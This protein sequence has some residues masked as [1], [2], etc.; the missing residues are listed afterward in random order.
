MAPSSTN[1]LVHVDKA[2]VW[3]QGDFVC[4][5]FDCLQ[6]DKA[7]TPS[8][9]NALVHVDPAP[10]WRQGV[11]FSKKN[12][13]VAVSSHELIKAASIKDNQEGKAPH[14]GSCV[15]CGVYSRFF[16]ET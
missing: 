4:L 3:C 11:F 7:A 13:C 16:L 6:L 12:F 8:L 10:V 14:S 2:P 1:A 5:L 15:P 9:N